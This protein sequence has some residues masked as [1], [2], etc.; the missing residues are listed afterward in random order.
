MKLIWTLIIVVS[1]TSVFAQEVTVKSAKISIN[2]T[3]NSQSVL[4]II[5]PN[6]LVSETN[7][8]IE[9]NVQQLEIQGIVQDKEGVEELSLNGAVLNIGPTGYFKTNV[10]I[11]EGS[12]E[13]VFSIKDLK[14]K[15]ETKQFLIEGN[16]VAESTIKNHY[17]LI[18][19]NNNYETS[20]LTN[21]GNDA[22]SMAKVLTQLGWDVNLQLDIGKRAMIDHLKD[23]GDKVDA[24]PN[25]AAL[26]FYAGHGL[27]H[28]GKNYL[29]PVDAEI[30]RA[31]DIEHECVPAD[32][33]L[34]MLE[35]LKNKMNIII[36]DACRN[37]PYARSFRSMDR[38]LA[39]PDN[40]PTGS[41]IAFSTAPG[42]V[43]SD[44][45]GENG[46]YTQ[47]LLKAMQVPGLTISQVFNTVRR[48]VIQMSNEKQ[49]PW[50]NSSLLGD[51]YF[52][53]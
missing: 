45:D 32:R 33:I 35:Y 7:D 34:T 28:N 1:S 22:S 27:Q 6:E 5:S 41:V 18:I 13:L 46:L 36:L 50:E 25:S 20:P 52:V 23:F 19:G 37:N 51:F 39:V 38:G 29:V 8:L 42:K 15:I 14:Q 11:V 24:T 43:A 49:V 9:M 17:A 26:F 31:Y 30:E 12:N 21:A 4:K 3:T 47:E 44:G 53:K 40:A 10:N 48:N 2:N 16:E